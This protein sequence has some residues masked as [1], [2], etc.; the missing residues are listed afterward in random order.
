M[1][2]AAMLELRRLAAA[3]EGLQRLVGRLAT[4]APP[5]PQTRVLEAL[6]AVYGH[7]VSFTSS[8][9]SDALNLHVE[10]R[11]ELRQALH[12]ALAG[13]APTPER[14]G[15]LLRGIV[16]AGPAAGW[17]LSTPGTDAGARIWML[18]SVGG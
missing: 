7:G 6:G 13:K 11:Q 5:P 3:V 18:E 4:H 12:V 8:D 1:T 17:L 2:D 14:I 9:V 15:R 16:A 10:T